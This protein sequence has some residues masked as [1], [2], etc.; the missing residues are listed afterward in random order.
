MMYSI[1]VPVYNVEKYLDRCIDSL[2]NQTY[3]DI[4]IILVDDGSD[5]ASPEMCDHFEKL[6][7][8]I[9]VIHQGNGGLSSAR[10]AGVSSAKGD[11]VMFIDS[12]DYIDFDT[13]ERFSKYTSNDYDV[14]TGSM[15][16]EDEY[17]SNVRKKGIRRYEKPELSGRELLLCALKESEFLAPAVLNIY[18]RRFLIDEGLSFRLGILH[19][20]EEFTPRVMLLAKSVFVSGETFYHYVIRENSI[21]TS[22]NQ[23]QNVIDIYS[24]CC[25][26]KSVYEIQTDG[27]LRRLL[28]DYLVIIYLSR[29]GLARIYSKQ[30]IHKRF[31]LENA[32]R[33]K[34]IIKA[35]IF[36]ISPRLYC[37]IVDKHLKLTN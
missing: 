4:E 2:I 33:L 9:R 16:V 30:L 24:I 29:F 25:E 26:L 12:D 19:E 21:T 5:D 18:N 3:N 11:Y 35:V 32:K 28:L 20:D 15:Y 13:C 6:D 37:W 14:I 36:C 23:T 8:R 7:E 1:I 31:A 17:K 10:N 22:L 27:E 34:T